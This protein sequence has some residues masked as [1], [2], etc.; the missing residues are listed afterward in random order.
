L[1][2]LPDDPGVRVASRPSVH[3]FIALYA[4][5]WAGGAIAYTPFLTLLLPLRA[6]A[7]AGEGAAI[8]WLAYLAFAG[9]IAA[10]L[11]NIGF[12]WLSDVTRNRRGW[13]ASGLAFSTAALCAFPRAETLPALIALIVIWQLGLNMMLGPLSAWAGDCV[14]DARKGLLGG[15]MAV[16]PALG[17]A[18]GALVTL[19]GLANPGERPLIVAA[20]V[21]TC[22]LPL[23]LF[24]TPAPVGGDPDGRAPADDGGPAPGQRRRAALM[25][26]ARLAVQVAEAAL[27]A[28]LF[29]W[30]R[31]LDPAMDENRVATVFA[32]VLAVSVPLALAAGAWADRARRPLLPL[33]LCAAVSAIGLGA[34]A[35]AATLAQAMAGYAVF[36][37]ASGIFLALHSAQTLRVLPRPERRGR[38]LGLFNLTNTVPSMVMPGLTLT[39]VPVFGFGGLFAILAA[40]AVLACVL[41]G[42]IS[43]SR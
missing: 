4:L 26:L 37:V 6:T 41:V 33:A 2:H 29:L 24:G 3:R 31:S 7:L 30:F 21:A 39:L 12:G 14:P 16:A 32:A 35:L 11:S 17:A 28:Y 43:R 22:I 23:L 15:L 5:A 18:S 8:T 19:P 40:L 34:M 13:I 20:I 38:D 10:S 27:F 1:P 9:A 42:A 36:G 25:W